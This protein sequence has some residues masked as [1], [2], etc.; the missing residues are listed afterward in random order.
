MAESIGGWLARVRAGRMSQQQ[1]ADALGVNVSTVGHWE[2]GRRGLND[3]PFRRICEVLD[4]PEEERT[5]GARLAMGLPP[6]KADDG[7]A[8]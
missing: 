6:E 4:L 7:V 3:E 1:L 8:A 5:R 2:A